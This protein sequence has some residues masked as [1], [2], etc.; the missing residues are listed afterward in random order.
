MYEKVIVITYF[1]FFKR[2]NKIRNKTLR[3]THFERKHMST[4]IK[5]KSRSQV[6]YYEGTI[7]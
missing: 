7:G 4:K 5:S 6:T 3:V 1:N 2:E